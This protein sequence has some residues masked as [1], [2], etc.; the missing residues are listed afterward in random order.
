MGKER[1][2]ILDIDFH[3]GISQIIPSTQQAYKTEGFDGEVRYV[4]KESLKIF[5]EKVGEV[6]QKDLAKQPQFPILFQRFASQND[7]GN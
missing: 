5:K 1:N 3:F 4:E 7:F 2:K 6:I